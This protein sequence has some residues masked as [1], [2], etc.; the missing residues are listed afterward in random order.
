MQ[1]GVQPGVTGVPESGK[2]YH[3]KRLAVKGSGRAV[4]VGDRRQRLLSHVR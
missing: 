2:F 4:A 1:Q 3:P